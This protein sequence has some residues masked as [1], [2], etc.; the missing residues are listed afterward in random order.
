MR[1]KDGLARLH[2]GEFAVLLEDADIQLA[3][4]I[5]DRIAQQLA[6]P[7]EIDGVRVSVDSL[8]SVTMGSD[9][10]M[11]DLVVAAEEPVYSA[12]ATGRP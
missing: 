10:M 3:H 4:S 1:P 9:G 8:V 12:R 2:E 11:A 7:V 5:A 6:S